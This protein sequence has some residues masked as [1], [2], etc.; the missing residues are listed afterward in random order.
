MPS[1]SWANEILAHLPFH[2]DQQRAVVVTHCLLPAVLR[3]V[4][5]TYAA[6]TLEDMW[7]DGLRW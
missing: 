7:A 3:S 2:L 4:V 1:V 5:V 6:T